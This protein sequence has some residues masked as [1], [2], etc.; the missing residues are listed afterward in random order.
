MPELRLY[1]DY[2]TGQLGSQCPISLTLTLTWPQI[3]APNM[4]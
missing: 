2:T 1:A 4:D 3:A